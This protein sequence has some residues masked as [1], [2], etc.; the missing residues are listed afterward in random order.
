MNSLEEIHAIISEEMVASQTKS[1]YQKKYSAIQMTSQSQ[2]DFQE[3]EKSKNEIK[4]TE[5]HK[6]IKK[7]RFEQSR[8]I[9]LEFKS[10]TNSKETRLLEITNSIKQFE[11]FFLII[12]KACL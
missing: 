5:F 8:N 3:N 10:R 11:V 9:Y 12:L 6:L 2:L 4:E 7:Q 1:L